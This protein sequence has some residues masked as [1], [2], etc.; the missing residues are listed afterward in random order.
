MTRNEITIADIGSY[1]LVNGLNMYYEIHG[2]GRP[3]ILLHG[4]V[5]AS[6]M[7]GSVLPTLAENSKVIAVHLQ[8]HGRTAD[9]DRPLRFEFM[10][11]D[12]A[13]LMK[14]LALESADIM[15]YS[16]GGGVALQT[17][18]RHPEVVRRLVLISTPNQAKWMVR[19]SFGEHGAN[20]SRCCKVHDAVT[21]PSALSQ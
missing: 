12:I 14:H 1:A 4:G 5:G 11:D 13:A 15:G 20:G 3:L 10:A 17:A 7:F 18:I 19:R 6:E 9:I 8:A 2:N 21:P 16:L